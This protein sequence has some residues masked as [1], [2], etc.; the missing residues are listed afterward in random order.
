MQTVV[1]RSP[2]SFSAQEIED[3][4]A[5]VL[6]GGEVTSQRLK[7][8][9]TRAK[10]IAFLRIGQCLTGV[11]G[12]KRPEPA[13]RSRVQ[14]GAKFS[15]SQESFPYELGWVFI[16]PSARGGKLSLP[17]CQP[18]VAAASASGVFATSRTKNKG[19]HATLEKLGFGCVGSAWASKQNE[20]NLMLFVKNA[21]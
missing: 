16:L 3:F 10:C 17:L 5:F 12:L 4:V 6:A 11:A 13:Y 15:L 14:K 20:D 2:E 19:M 1:A 8:R 18:V 9:V 7:E 21:A